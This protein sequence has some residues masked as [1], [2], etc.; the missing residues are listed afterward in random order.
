MEEFVFEHAVG[1][2]ARK[3]V[4]SKLSPD[5]QL[6]IRS[7]DV[8]DGVYEGSDWN[9][10]LPLDEKLMEAM[11]PCEAVF[12]NLMTRL[13]FART[14]PYAERRRLY[15][16]HLRYWNDYLERHKINLLLAGIIPH[17]IPDYVIYGLCKH[18][19]IPTLLFHSTPIPDCA[20]LMEDW[21]ESAVQLQKRYQELAHQFDGTQSE[22]IPLT[23]RFEEYFQKQMEPSGRKPITFR[24]PSPIDRIRASLRGNFLHAL[25]T[26]VHWLPTLLS[27]SAWRRR[28][29]KYHTKRYQRSLQCFYDRHAVDPELSK[30]FVYV[31]LHF[32][33]ECSTCPMAGA[34]VNQQIMVQLLSNSIPEGVFLYVKEHPVQRIRGF[35]CRSIDFYR[36]LLALPNVRLIRHDADSFA[37]REHCSAVVTGTGTAGFEALF[38]EKPVLMFGH[39]FYQYAPGVF[40]IR[41]S[42]D[43]REAMKAIFDRRETPTI[44]SIRVF[45]K[46][47]EETCVIASIT[48]WHQQQASTLTHDEGARGI[49]SALIDYLRSSEERLVLQR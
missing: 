5:Q 35:A 2:G 14:I 44:S 21:E 23:E 46:A 1:I 3:M 41:T 37:L 36:H 16:L 8:R 4:Y 10:L 32:Q 13:E 17:E 42:E 28:F 49:S 43:C 48:D 7:G 31:P 38:R 24:R 33:P 15:F 45:L 40:P 11:R 25:K 27:R 22:D 9:A 6:W 34:Y 39:H 29:E 19:R 26:F 12:M 47:M 18:K 30:P 20:F